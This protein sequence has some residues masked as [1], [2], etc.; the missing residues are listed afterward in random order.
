MSTNDKA[1]DEA[2]I[3]ANTHSVIQ[4]QEALKLLA[5]AV[6]TLKGVKSQ[7]ASVGAETPPTAQYS[8]KNAMEVSSTGVQ[9]AMQAAED[10]VKVAIA[11][12]EQHI[13]TAMQSFPQ[14][15][16][17]GQPSTETK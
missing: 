14:L 8:I 1:M 4:I 2:L 13:Q 7:D 16:A 6:K 5:N 17:L 15:T 9:D 10:G 12:A 3:T 11:N